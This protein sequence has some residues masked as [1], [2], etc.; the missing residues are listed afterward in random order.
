M[1]RNIL[2][3]FFAILSFST[4][5]IFAQKTIKVACVGNSITYG[6]GIVNREKN[7]YPAQL[8]EYLGDNY[9]VK[10]FGVSARTVLIKGDY[11]YVETDVY[12]QSLAYQPDVVLI[13]LGTN[14]TKPQNWK[15]QDDFL[16]DYQALIDSYRM[17]S[18]HPRIILLTPIRC[19]LPE[20]SSINAQFIE[21]EVRPMVEELAWKNNL[22][23]INMFNIFGDEFKDYLTPDKL[24]P[25]SI[26][27][28][29]M[30]KK[31]YNYLSLPHYTQTK[32]IKS[33]IPQ[34]AK[35]FNFHGYQGYEFYDRGVLCKIVRPY[36]DANGKPWVIRARFWGHE[37]QTDIDLLEQGFYITYCDV[38][39]LYGSNKAV[40]R[41]N[42]FYK[43]MVKAGL[44][45]KVVLEGMSRGGLIVYNWAAKNSHKVACIY[46]DA[47]VMDFKSWPMGKGK[48]TK[49]EDDTKKLF[50]AYGFMNENQAIEWKHNPLDWAEIIAKAKIPII[51]VVGDADVVVP[52]DENT[53]VFEERMKNFNAPITVIHKPGIGHH[54]HSL[55]NPEPIV[56]FILAAT[57]RKSNDCT[58]ALPGNEFR[59]G[60]GWVKG[61]DWHNVSEDIT[62]TLQNKRL[63][64]LLLG[65]SITQAW[66]GTRQLITTFTG[67][68][69]MDEAIGE[70]TW[71][72]A[73]ISGDRTQNLL[74]RLQNGNYNICKPENVVIA[75]GINNLIASDT[76][77]DTA[78]GIIAVAEEARKQ[79]PESRIIL[80]G[81]YPSGKYQQDP[82][83]IKCDKVHDILSSHQ[84]NQV[85]YINPTEW[86]L[87]NNNVI[88]E[89]LYSSDYIH[90]TSEGY[91]I[92]A[93]KIVRLLKN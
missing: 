39:D 86:Y 26:G 9:E 16:E 91:K 2:Y 69:A 24:H 21:K 38:A 47:P 40:E 71:E 62:E 33:L 75:I 48:S 66:G 58:H 74:W 50:T 3:L 83:R 87:D 68:Q 89:G 23:I 1:K 20:G 81:L 4:E 29:L 88:R 51:H 77:E 76:P 32:P 45:K 17:L 52:V 64:L 72:N 31:I 25:S 28:G 19:F 65:N 49:S 79:F 36:R 43:K 18:S 27:A 78:E 22:E 10:N 82:I 30:A 11:P 13:K 46:A 54:P 7:S 92:T 59:S 8:Q 73:G 5:T 70:G 15:Y 80:L 90:M 93:D 56:R 14:D 67:K 34:N 12:K 57:G 61:S 44:N 37:P 85:E 60:A 41:W 55:N 53:A 6:A 35:K 42:R 84:F 63:K